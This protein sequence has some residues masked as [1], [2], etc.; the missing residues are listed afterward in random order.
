MAGEIARIKA[1]LNFLLNEIVI[2][3]FHCQ[4]WNAATISKDLFA[5]FVVT[6]YRC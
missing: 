4:I 1:L 5:S 6:V 2:C 3:C